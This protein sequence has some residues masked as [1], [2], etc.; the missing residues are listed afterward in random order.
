[1][2]VLHRRPGALTHA[3]PSVFALTV[4]STTLDYSCA[5]ALP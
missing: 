2:N 3:L 4:L 1:M 5:A